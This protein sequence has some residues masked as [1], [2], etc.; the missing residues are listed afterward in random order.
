MEN[1]DP[2]DHEKV[3]AAIKSLALCPG[4]TYWLKPIMEA[5]MKV[6]QDQLLEDVAKAETKALRLEHRLLKELVD[7]PEA[8]MRS[9]VKHPQAA[10][11]NGAV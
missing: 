9:L 5:R 7:R 8:T 2:R 3:A 6:I 1:I 10:T 4:W 11:G